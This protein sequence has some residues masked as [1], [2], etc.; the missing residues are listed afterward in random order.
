MDIGVNF[1]GWGVGCIGIAIYIYICIY[2]FYG[3]LFCVTRGNKSQPERGGEG[4][5][6]NKRS[7]NKAVCAPKYSLLMALLRR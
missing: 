5:K 2:L 6:L 7:H 3:G 4:T 1:F